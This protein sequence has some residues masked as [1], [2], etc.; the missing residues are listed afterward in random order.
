MRILV[1]DENPHRSAE[2]IEG[3]R[4]EG[5]DI[6]AVLGI[7]DDLRQA[8]ARHAPDIVVIDLE[9]PYRDYLEDLISINRESP[10]PI[11]MFVGEE[12]RALSARA[13]ETG[14]SVY[15]VDGLSAKLVHSVLGIAVAQFSRHRALEKE[16]ERSR[17]ALDERKVV[18][19]A[20]G[21]LMSGRGLSE[22]EAYKALRKMAMD[23]GKKLRDIAEA[24]LALADVIRR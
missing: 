16:L 9:S 15:A 17:L 1:V 12:D 11:A 4:A 6:V 23:Q 24:V 10:R 21:V 14:V 19:R 2:V 7:A 5:H 3:L 13:L 22:E 8:I 18:E 20:K